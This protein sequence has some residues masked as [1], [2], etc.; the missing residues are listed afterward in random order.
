M[1]YQ[2]IANI[3]TFVDR[4]ATSQRRATAHRKA[5]RQNVYIVRSVTVTVLSAHHKAKIHHVLT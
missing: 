2:P 1:N 4:R 5:H 3:A